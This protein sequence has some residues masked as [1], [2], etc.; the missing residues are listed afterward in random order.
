MDEMKL[1]IHSSRHPSMDGITAAHVV[2]QSLYSSVFFFGKISSTGDKKQ[3]SATSRK[4][5]KKKTF[6]TFTIFL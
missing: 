4:E 3:P 2:K 5:L 1:S 6:R